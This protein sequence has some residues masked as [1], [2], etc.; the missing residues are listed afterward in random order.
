MRSAQGQ[1]IVFYEIDV[2]LFIYM[3]ASSIFSCFFSIDIY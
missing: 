1:I 2:Y 3:I